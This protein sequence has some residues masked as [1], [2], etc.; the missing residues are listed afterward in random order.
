MCAICQADSRE[1][2]APGSEMPGLDAVQDG[3]WISLV[4]CPSCSQLW[5]YSPFE[6]YAAFPYLVKWPRAAED[7]SRIV[8]ADNSATMQEW[9]KN[10]IRRL[11]ASAPPETREKIEAHQQR[12]YGQ[13]GLTQPVETNPVDLDQL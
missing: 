11:Y 9:M 13:Y 2:W 7:W 6:P 10:E 4:R 8:E 1:L 5:V 12:S 3:N